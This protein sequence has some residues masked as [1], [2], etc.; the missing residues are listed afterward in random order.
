M[1]Q[2]VRSY[3]GLV[4][5][6]PEVQALIRTC[7]RSGLKKYLKKRKRK[8]H[9]KKPPAGIASAEDLRSAPSS[10][11]AK[12]IASVFLFFATSSK[13]SWHASSVL[14]KKKTQDK[15]KR[16]CLELTASARVY[17]DTTHDAALK[18]LH[19]RHYSSDSTLKAQLLRHNS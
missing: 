1:T 5:D 7:F 8:H 10:E 19:L 4:S 17:S 9:E 16:R 18:A 11:R 15:V 3:R 6:T 2:R 14:K 13:N 12:S